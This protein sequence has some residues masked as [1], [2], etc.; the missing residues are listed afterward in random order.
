MYFDPEPKSKKEDLYNFEKEYKALHNAIKRNERIIVIKGIRRTGKTSLMKVVY[1][2]LK[3]PKAFI[4]GRIIPPKQKD[5]F[6]A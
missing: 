2:E 1:N 4:D 3:N 5:I 6:N